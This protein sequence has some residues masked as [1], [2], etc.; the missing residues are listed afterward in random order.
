MRVFS[1][2]TPYFLI[3][4][5]YLLSLFPMGEV[6]TNDNC[7]DLRQTVKNLQ[8]L[9]LEVADAAYSF[10][11][12]FKQSIISLQVLAGLR[13]VIL[14]KHNPIEDGVPILVTISFRSHHLPS[15]GVSLSQNN[16]TNVLLPKDTFSF[17][18]SLDIAPETPP[19]VSV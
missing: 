4:G 17:Y 5:F 6:V 10:D 2:R 7:A 1:G 19:P 15:G 3:V 16:S 11:E 8:I 9:E 14:L 12:A 18:N 13:T